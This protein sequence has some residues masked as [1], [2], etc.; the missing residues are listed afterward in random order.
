[1]MCLNYIADEAKIKSD[2]YLN[3]IKVGDFTHRKKSYTRSS[4]VWDVFNE[5]V[6]DSGDTI[7]DFFFCTKCE[8]I[9][10]SVRSGG[11]T[12]KLLRHGCVEP[13][14]STTI[15][16]DSRELKNI[17]HAAANF[18][19][20]DFRPFYAVECIGLRGLVVA[21]FNLG[22][23]H[24]A[25][26][27]VEFLG[28]FPSRQT[29]KRY[30]ADEAVRAKTAMKTLFRESINQGGLG[31]VMDLGSDRYNS[32]SYLAM[33]ANVFLLRE[34]SLEHKGVIFHMGLIPDLVKSKEVIKSRILEVFAEFDVSPSEIKEFITFTTDR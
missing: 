27:T 28:H 19:C 11:S 2:E 25:M 3:L 18:V 16:I 23:K 9:V 10:Y 5:I 34:N 6:D 1:M 22:Q 30:V 13:T 15:N 31:C 14:Q 8:K 26:K 29:V 20:S 32:N 7:D 17:K 4:N 33:T 12:T 24:P 21:G